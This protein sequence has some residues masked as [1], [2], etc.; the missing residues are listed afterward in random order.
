MERLKSYDS[1][2]FQ[3]YFTP[4]QFLARQ[5]YF[6]LAG[7][8][9]HSHRFANT[10]ERAAWMLHCEGMSQRDIAKALSIKRHVVEKIIPELREQML[11]A[12]K[13]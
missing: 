3:L 1:I 12:M 6:E 9:Y 2:R 5:L 11:K 13:K 10:T 7:E 8:F 4:D